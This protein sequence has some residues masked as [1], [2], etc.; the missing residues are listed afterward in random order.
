MI[1]FAF[2]IALVLF[3]IWMIPQIIVFIGCLA[4]IL[5]SLLGE[6]K[7]G[8]KPKPPTEKDIKEAEEEKEYTYAADY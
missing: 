2:Q 8:N 5:W 1:G 3:I 4:I 6:S 7:G